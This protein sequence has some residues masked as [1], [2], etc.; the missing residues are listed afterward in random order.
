MAAIVSFIGWHDCGKTTLATGVV[1]SLNQMGYRVAVIKSSSERNI[2]FDT[3]ETDTFKHKQAGADSVMLV[4]PDQMV[5]QTKQKDLSNYLK[6]IKKRLKNYW[7]PCLT[8][9]QRRF[10]IA[11]C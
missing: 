10:E 1:A 7:A 4:A 2:E 11:P 5:L 8:Q 3:P 6:R 9:V